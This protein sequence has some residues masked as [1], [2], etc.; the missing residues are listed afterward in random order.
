MKRV[1]GILLFTMALLCTARLG[2]AEPESSCD[3]SRQKMSAAQIDDRIR[4]ENQV[5]LA[6]VQVT[7]VWPTSR[8]PLKATRFECDRCCFSQ[9]MRIV[10]QSVEMSIEISNSE[11]RG[12]VFISESEFARPMILR[13]ATFGGGVQLLQ[14]TF[15]SGLDMRDSTFTREVNVEQGL[16]EGLVNLG[17]TDFLAPVDVIGTDFMN[18]IHWEN[19]NFHAPVNLR[20]SL[21][22]GPIVVRASRVSSSWTFER[23]SILAGA[24]FRFT[25]FGGCDEQHRSHCNGHPTGSLDIK[26]S[27][28]SS[29]LWLRSVEAD[30]AESTSAAGEK[31][32]DDHLLFISGSSIQSIEGKNWLELKALMEPMLSSLQADDERRLEVTSTLRQ[33]EKGFATQGLHDD[34]AAVEIYRRQLEANHSGMFA[35]VGF[36][37]MKYTNQYG[38]QLWR[39]PLWCLGCI[40][41]F[42]GIYFLEATARRKKG[43]PVTVMLCFETSLRVFTN[44]RSPE[45]GKQAL[46]GNRLTRRLANIEQFVGFASLAATTVVVGGFVSA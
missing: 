17:G 26:D 18:S 19:S 25:K 16:I 43:V 20:E 42:T 30:A 4:T 37:F 8:S 35:L 11:F 13:R 38:H 10:H 23:S 14:A 46:H 6:D 36:Y 27:L 3:A 41:V 29:P 22:A 40:F 21:F 45:D 15:A 33:I 7:D 31:L 2:R 28:F 5:R 32:E 39:M 12:P 24:D 9:G 1:I 34:A 44:L